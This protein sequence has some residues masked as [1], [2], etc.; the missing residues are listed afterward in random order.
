[1]VVILAVRGLITLL[2]GVI[3]GRMRFISLGVLTFI[4]GAWM[5]SI[6]PVATDASPLRLAQLE[7]PGIRFEEPNLGIGVEEIQSAL[8]WLS[9]EVGVTFDC[10]DSTPVGELWRISC[11]SNSAPYSAFELFGQLDE[12]EEQEEGEEDRLTPLIRVTLLMGASNTPSVARRGFAVVVALMSEIL[13][14]WETGLI[15]FS[16][17]VQSG[18]EEQEHLVD[19]K[20]V[21]FANRLSTL[22]GMLVSFEPQ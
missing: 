18:T 2:T 14:E 12:E 1:M 22:G 6:A 5:M 7:V 20:R 9:S 3:K 4:V 17:W 16:Q 11:E 15:A 13:P 10:T 21:T 8:D 19:G